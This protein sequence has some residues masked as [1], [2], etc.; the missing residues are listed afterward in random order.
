VERKESKRE[1]KGKLKE[2]CLSVCVC[3]WCVFRKRREEAAK[4]REELKKTAAV[5]APKVGIEEGAMLLLLECTLDDERPAPL[6][7]VMGL[8][9]ALQV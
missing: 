8:T 2:G 3:F 7:A 5:E 1:L 4:A 6:E 9:S